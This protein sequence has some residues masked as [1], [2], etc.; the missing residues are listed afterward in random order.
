MLTVTKWIPR[1]VRF[2]LRTVLWT[3]TAAIMAEFLW[4]KETTWFPFARK[5]YTKAM[6]V[7]TTK[8]TQ[9]LTTFIVVRFFLTTTFIWQWTT[10]FV[11]DLLTLLL[12]VR[13]LRH[14]LSSL[15]TVFQL[16]TKLF[17]YIK[18]PCHK[19]FFMTTIFR[20]TLWLIVT[21][22]TMY[23]WRMLVTGIRF[24]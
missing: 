15:G 16:I 17:K 10:R 8:T 21:G 23:L 14:I 1:W 22:T 20:L 7:L 2:L 13:L 24:F 19:T 18:K 5:Y 3:E 4:R 6:T 12:L 11:K 9:L